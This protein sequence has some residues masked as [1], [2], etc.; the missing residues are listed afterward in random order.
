MAG[1]SGILEILDQLPLEQ[2]DAGLRAGIESARLQ[3]DSAQLGLLARRAVGDL[4]L[5]GD[6]VRVAVAGGSRNGN[7]LLLV[8][9]TSRLLDCAALPREPEARPAE[10]AAAAGSSAEDELE[11]EHSV[12]ATRDTLL[13]P[14]RQDIVEM[15]NAM[16]Q[17]QDLAVGDPR[18]D[19]PWVM[20]NRILEL[21]QAYLPDLQLHAQ[22][23][24]VQGEPEVYGRL[25]PQPDLSD[26]PFWLR[27]RRVGQS[28]WI[29]V[30]SELPASLRHR[31]LLSGEGSVVTAVVP[32]VGPA[33]ED[34][35]TGL[36]YVTGTE[37]WDAETLLKLARRLSV[38]VSRRW[39]CQRDVNRRVLTDSLTGVPNR[40]FFDTQFP[41]ELERVRRSD[42]PLT[43]VIGDLDHF[44]TIN[45]TYGHQCGDLVLRSVARQLLAA[46]RRIDVVCRIGGEEFACIL[47]STSSEEAREVLARIV[48]R[49]F[50]VNLPPELGVGVLSITV[51]FGAVTFPQAG[52]SA[53]ELHR[54]ADALLYQAKERGR[55]RCC[56]WTN[57]GIIELQQSPN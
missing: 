23:T 57:T 38:F 36:L 13:T 3:G 37:S 52:S 24:V 34:G 16:E 2:L 25:L 53:G 48:G 26:M 55:N 4:L 14:R 8:H 18:A 39:R 45:D 6:L 32:I 28:L 46:L 9:G 30:A 10:S 15:L 1:N 22:L 43:L 5:S 21:L 33:A 17:A 44:K 56:L 29:P 7:N 50:K 31:L 40:A 20:V 12:P 19:D 41:L 49:P 47:P 42:Q 27:H 51:S 54:K 11:T 35:E